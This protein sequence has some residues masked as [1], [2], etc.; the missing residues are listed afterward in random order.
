[1]APPDFQLDEVRS[2]GF[3]CRM[4]FSSQ[5]FGSIK[6]D[7]AICVATYGLESCRL[8]HGGCACIQSSSHWKGRTENSLYETV[9]RSYRLN[10]GPDRKEG[11]SDS[12][13]NNG[14]Q[15]ACT[16]HLSQRPQRLAKPI[17]PFC[18]ESPMRLL[19]H[20]HERSH[21]AASRKS[22]PYSTHS[23]DSF[24]RSRP[25]GFACMTRY[26]IS[27]AKA[28][29]AHAASLPNTWTRGPGLEGSL[30]DTPTKTWRICSSNEKVFTLATDIM[31]R[32]DYCESFLV[33]LPTYMR[34]L[35]QL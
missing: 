4:L 13:R 26:L 28:I 6:P 20:R 5:L 31:A 25:G 19:L 32:W 12:G 8:H 29:S 14:T 11:G 15:Y 2:S 22:S 18:T 7:P 17:Q 3:L 30:L 27:Q 33:P 23:L 10:R 34:W 1:M 9:N 35:R 24:S 21:P 16:E